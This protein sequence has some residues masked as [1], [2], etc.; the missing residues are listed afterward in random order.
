MSIDVLIVD[1]EADIRDLVA[2]ILKDDGYNPRLAKDSK[3]ALEAIEERVP[4]ALVLDIWLQGSQMDGLGIL[5]AV[6]NKYPHLPVIMIS[7]HGNIETAI[8]SIKL[9]AYDFIEKPFKED[10]LLLLLR[11]AIE[12]ARLKLENEELKRRGAY[13]SQLIG[14]SSA[15]TNLR[16]MIDKVS[17][18]ESRILITGAAGCG[19]EVVARGIHERS[20]R[21]HRPFVVLSSAS[22]ADDNIDSEL[23]G[24]NTKAGAGDGECKLGVFERAHG[25]TLFIDDVSDMSTSTQ[26]KLLRILQNK[27]FERIGS[28]KSVDIDVRVIAASTKDLQKEIKE[29]RFRE[30]LYY[31]LNVVPIQIP[32]LSE[33]KEDIV[34]LMEYFIKRCAN[35]LGMK[36]RAISQNAIASMQSYSWPGNVRQLRNVIERLLIM[37]PEDD[38]EPISSKMLP[39]EM[40]TANPATARPESNADI[41]GLPLR[42]A[43]EIFE[44][45]YLTAQLSRFD[46]NIS[47]TASFIGMERSAFHRKLKLLSINNNEKAETEECETACV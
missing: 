20:P 14:S 38:S 23:F 16:N 7:G 24:Q 3:S 42:A 13:E 25:G 22:L 44:K 2:D 41:M 45:Q 18:T 31:R 39:E 19:K 30:D 9:G 33:R 1:D 29:G 35:I 40:L 21:A 6:K 32:S 34:P 27:K 28:S 26:G 11:R 12:T 15:V 43:R 5:E 4:S 46:G 10:R 8:N 36:P 17:Q 37:A 47:R